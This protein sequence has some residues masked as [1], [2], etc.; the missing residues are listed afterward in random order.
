MGN[1]RRVFSAADFSHRRE[2]EVSLST[3]DR[4]IRNGEVEVLRERRWV[5]IAS[6]LERSATR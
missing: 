4:K 2:L 6:G 1:F 3:P 5:R